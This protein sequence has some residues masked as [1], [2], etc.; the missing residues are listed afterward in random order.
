M[1]SIMKT[2]ITSRKKKRAK[3]AKKK[4]EED[5][6]TFFALARLSLLSFGVI[7]KSLACSFDSCFPHRR[8]RKEEM[9][10]E[11]ETS[12]II[13]PFKDRMLSKIELPP[14]AL[15]P[16]INIRLRTFHSVEKNTSFLHPSTCGPGWGNF[17]RGDNA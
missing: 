1:I 3:K 10:K 2:A 16:D 5:F 7:A 12:K 8:A 6:F 14:S 4:S 9:E 15:A 11:E 17:P 13:S